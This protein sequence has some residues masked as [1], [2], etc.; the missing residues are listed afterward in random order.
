MTNKFF[1]VKQKISRRDFLRMV[2]R[3]TA[4]VFAAQVLPM[5][6]LWEKSAGSKRIPVKLFNRFDI[7][8]AHRWLG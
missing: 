2:M 5:R 6:L 8:R 3:V 4:G 7:Y 1:S